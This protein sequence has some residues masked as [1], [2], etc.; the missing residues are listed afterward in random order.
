[1]LDLLPYFLVLG[2]VANSLEFL[3]RICRLVLF[4][5]DGFCAADFADGRLLPILYDFHIIY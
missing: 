3:Q 5:L 4:I 1:M 2:F